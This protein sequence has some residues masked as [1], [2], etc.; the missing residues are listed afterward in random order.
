MTKPVPP[1][2]PPKTLSRRFWLR[3]TALL[4][5]A[6]TLSLRGRPAAAGA[7]APFAQPDAAGPTAFLDRAFAMRR[8]AEAA[9][10]QAYGAVVA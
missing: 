7:D 8:Q 4:G 10:D 3:T 6:L 5:L 2:E 1:G 9:G